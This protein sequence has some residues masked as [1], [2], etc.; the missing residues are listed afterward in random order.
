MDVDIGFSYEE[1]HSTIFEVCSGMLMGFLVF[2][3][4][5]CLI[6]KTEGTF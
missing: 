5:N 2:S 4:P 1:V 6:T 3:H